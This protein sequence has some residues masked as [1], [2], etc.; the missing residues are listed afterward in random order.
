[1]KKAEDRGSKAVL[2]G[3]FL[4]SLLIIF[5]FGVFVGIDFSF[6]QEENNNLGKINLLGD[7]ETKI[8]IVAVDDNGNGVSGLLTTQVREGTGLVLVNINDVLAD[9]NTQ[10]SARTA[11]SVAGAYAGVDLSNLDVIYS[12]ETP[13]QLISGPSAGSAMAVTTASLLQDK[14]INPNIVITGSVLENGD[15]GGAGAVIEKAKAAQE[16]GAT[17][18]LVPNNVEGLSYQEEKSCEHYDGNEYCRVTYKAS[19]INGEENLD[20]KIKQV[21]NINEAMEIF[22]L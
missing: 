6:N 13:A 9:Y 8:N 3:I 21:G 4:V 18:F 5:G 22:Y 20:I 7:K 11:A 12:I 15:L 10:F 19:K 2:F 1:M 17:L 14:E 16:A